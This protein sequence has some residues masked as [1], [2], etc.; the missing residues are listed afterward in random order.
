M[1]NGKP[2]ISIIMAVYEPRMDWLAE[3]LKSLDEQTY[4]NLKLYIRD[5]CSPTVPYEEI[6]SCVREHIRSFPWE[7]CRNEQ[8]LGSNGTFEL[9]TSEGEGEYFAYC[10]QD[11]VWLPEKLEVLQEA[12]ESQHAELVCSDMFIIDGT[13]KQTADSITKVRRRHKFSS[14]ENLAKELLITDFVT[15]CTM[16]IRA[17]TAR[18]A[19]PFC[20]YM[21]HDHYLALY[22]ATQGKIISLPDRL[23]R[24]RIHGGNQ[25][26]LMVGIHDKASYGA[27]Q[28]DAMLERLL[29]LRERFPELPELNEAVAWARA[30]K[31]N[32]AHEGGKLT[33]WKYRRF[34]LR[35]SIVEIFTGWLPE[36]MFRA[37][38]AAARRGA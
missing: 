21:I 33:I 12:I 17:E 18:A 6:E 5:D 2:M 37:V 15:G 25:T 7:M 3:Q 10:D 11:D 31:R 28:I 14:G 8:N 4:P 27:V 36:C 19:M 9:L 23:V 32:W 30:R 26:G 29:W 24:Y 22:A 20:P 38:I 34:S 16:L 13:G 35:P 1:E